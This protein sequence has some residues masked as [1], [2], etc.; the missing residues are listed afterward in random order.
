MKGMKG[1]E[2][3]GVIMTSASS[4]LFIKSSISIRVN[5]S[6]IR[7]LQLFSRTV[8]AEWSMLMGLKASMAYTESVWSSDLYILGLALPV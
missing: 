6:T 1:V 2:R 8:V 5:L 4:N 7:L 3:A